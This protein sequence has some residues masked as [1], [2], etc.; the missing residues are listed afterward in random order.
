LTKDKNFSPPRF[1]LDL[2]LEV[3][4]ARSA[5]KRFDASAQFPKG[6]IFAETYSSGPVQGLSWLNKG[7]EKKLLVRPAS[8]LAAERNALAKARRALPPLLVPS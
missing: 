2:S 7:D 5:L 6:T 3:Q 8:W 1:G 4:V